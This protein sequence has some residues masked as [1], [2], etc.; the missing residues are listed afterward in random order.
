EPRKGKR[1]FSAAFKQEV[2]S[3]IE[4][5]NLSLREARL[6]FDLSNEQ[7]ILSWQR[8]LREFGLSGLEP[9]PKG[10]PVMAD[11]LP[12]N[13]KRRRSKQPLTKEEELLQELEYLRA[14]NALLKKLQ[15]LAQKET[16]HKP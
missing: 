8:R 15:A 4:K 11:K 10:R 13:P 1:V 9:G 16:K 3:T 5:E 2:L 12:I 14:E 7:I 6:R